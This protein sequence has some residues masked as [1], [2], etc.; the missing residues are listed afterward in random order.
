MLPCKKG[1][2]EK[3]VRTFSLRDRDGFFEGRKGGAF[4]DGVFFRLG[5]VFHYED[6]RK[7]G[8]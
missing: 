5:A 4:L 7:H 2:S 1:R 3:G 8:R 6:G